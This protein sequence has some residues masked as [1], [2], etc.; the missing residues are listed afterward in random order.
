MKLC[1]FLVQ[2]SELQQQ[3][4]CRKKKGQLDNPV[5][6]GILLQKGFL[7]HIRFRGQFSG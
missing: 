4:F 1:V 3:F 5:F 2:K 7:I 6:L